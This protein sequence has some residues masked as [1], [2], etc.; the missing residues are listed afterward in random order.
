MQNTSLTQVLHE[1]SGSDTLLDFSCINTTFLLPCFFPYRRLLL[2]KA[3][4]PKRVCIASVCLPDC[5]FTHWP[6]INRKSF[7]VFCPGLSSQQSNIRRVVT[8]DSEFQQLQQDRQ[9]ILSSREQLCSVVKKEPDEVI[10]RHAFPQVYQNMA[11]FAAVP[12]IILLP[13]T[14]KLIIDTS[15]PTNEEK[16]PFFKP[17]F[18][19]TPREL[20]IRPLLS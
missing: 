5:L 6:Q 17:M 19:N 15:A 16:P 9:D 1:N 7:D 3:M 8:H 20:Y 12:Y 14:E 13:V 10:V 11:K 2:W 18:K 4:L